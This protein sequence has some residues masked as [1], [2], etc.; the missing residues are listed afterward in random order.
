M[1]MLHA[2]HWKT[3]PRGRKSAFSPETVQHLAAKHGFAPDNIQALGMDLLTAMRSPVKGPDERLLKRQRTKGE[4]RR[5]RARARIEQAK[6]AL[7]AADREM[8]NLKAE[9][10]YVLGAFD[11]NPANWHSRLRQIT[12]ELERLRR[13]LEFSGVLEHELMDPTAHDKRLDRDHV[14]INVLNAV[15]LFWQ[16]QGLPLTL[17]T[18]PDRTSN[19]ITGPL[20][21][22][23]RDIVADLT[24][25]ANILSADTLKAD[26]TRA[27]AQWKDCKEP[28]QLQAPK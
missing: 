28:Q 5:D 11:R 4:A 2:L 21:D 14:R 19:T 26:L 12:A 8:S 27:R 17:T 16:E 7:A 23:A 22:F 1:A 9:D 24:T 18:R 6:Q 3:F 10:A 15:F 13:D 25:H 20:L